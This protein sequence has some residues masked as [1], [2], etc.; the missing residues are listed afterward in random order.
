MAAV[1]VAVVAVVVVAVV[2]VVVATVSVVEHL[3]PSLNVGGH[4]A[5]VGDDRGD[6][7]ADVRVVA[8][9]CPNTSAICSAGPRAGCPLSP[10]SARPT[11]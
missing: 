1:A 9:A 6:G 8:V 11:Y 4:H 2:A 7:G 10:Y 3:H 5:L